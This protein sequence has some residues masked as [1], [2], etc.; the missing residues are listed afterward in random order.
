MRVYLLTRHRR[1]PMVS[2]TVIAVIIRSSASVTIKTYVY[3]PHALPDIVAT[4][5]GTG[6]C[7][8]L[9]SKLHPGVLFEVPDT[10]GEQTCCNQ[11]KEARRDD[12]EDL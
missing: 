11:V 9:A 12:E 10:F 7:S 1:F 5:T 3:V 2:S 8:T 6:F 4:R